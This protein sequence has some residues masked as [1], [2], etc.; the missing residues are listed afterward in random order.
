MF[1]IELQRFGL[2]VKKREDLLMNDTITL[3][4]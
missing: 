2:E 4:Q 3:G 1:N